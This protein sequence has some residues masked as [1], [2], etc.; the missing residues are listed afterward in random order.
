[1]RQLRKTA[2][3]GAS[4]QS[5]T[6]E[7]TLQTAIDTQRLGEEGLEVVASV[8]DAEWMWIRLLPPVVLALAWARMCSWFVGRSDGC[9]GSV[10]SQRPPALLEAVRQ[11]SWQSVEPILFHALFRPINLGLGPHTITSNVTAVHV[12][13]NCSCK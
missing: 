9:S 6:R 5:C 12:G 1:M 11:G 4:V 13:C 10:C 3:G 2:Q 8:T 7:T